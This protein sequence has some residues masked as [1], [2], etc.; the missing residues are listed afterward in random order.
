MAAGPPAPSRSFQAASAAGPAGRP[1]T[2]AMRPLLLLAPLGWLLLAEAK[3]EA[4]PEG[5][6]AGRGPGG[7]GWGGWSGGSWSAR[8]AW[9][10]E[11]IRVPVTWPLTRW[12]LGRITSPVGAAVPAWVQPGGEGHGEGQIVIA[13]IIVITAAPVYGAL[14]MGQAAVKHDLNPPK[15]AL[16]LSPFARWAN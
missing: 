10:S 7:G 4:K 13:P 5:E 3:G 15:C 2:P 14:T 6:G 16:L 8:E 1:Q 12:R 9:A 11:G